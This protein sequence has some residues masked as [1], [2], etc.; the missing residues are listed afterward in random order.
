MGENS[1]MGFT[2]FTHDRVFLFHP[3]YGTTAS[4]PHSDTAFVGLNLSLSWFVGSVD[5]STILF[6]LSVSIS[7]SMVTKP[8]CSITKN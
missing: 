7:V 3:I 8:L 6:T 5:Q 1:P 4:I 2:K